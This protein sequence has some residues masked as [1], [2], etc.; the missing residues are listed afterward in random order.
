MT[1]RITKS[2]LA[3]R[4]NVKPPYI[5]KLVKQKKLIFGID[6]LIDYEEAL[7]QLNKNTERISSVV[8]NEQVQNDELVEDYKYWKTE[9]EKW[10]AKQ[11]QLEFEEK[12]KNLIPRS[13]VEEDGFL[14]GNLVKEQFLS[15]P[16]SLC[17]IFAAESDP[18]VIR[19]Q[20]L[21][22]T[23]R[24]LTELADKLGSLNK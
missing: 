21:K 24:I 12:Q 11:E 16:E 14:I 10:K 17:N 6:G 1:E 20:W 7:K 13:K 8:N 22:E 19:E 15:L 18:M 9:S 2:E 4:L 3:K 23:K 5:S